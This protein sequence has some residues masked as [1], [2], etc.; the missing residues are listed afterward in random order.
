M[1]PPDFLK[2]LASLPGLDLQAFIGV[3]QEEQAPTSIR[4]NPL[5]TSAINALFEGTHAVPWSRLGHYLPDRPAFALDPLWHAGAYYVQEASSMVIEQVWHQWM[6]PNNQNLRV[7]DLCAAPGGKSTHLLSLLGEQDLLVSNEVIGS[8]ANVLLENITKWGYVNSMVTNND[9]ADFSELEGLFDMIVVDA[10]CSGSGLFR[11]DPDAAEEWSLDAVHLCQKRQQRILADVWPALKEEGI[12]IY[13]TCSYSEAEDET[14]LDWL[15]EHFGATSLPVE[16]NPAWKV[17]P[18]LSPK[19]GAHGYRF[20]QHLLEGEGFFLS[21]VRKTDA[22]GVFHSKGRQNRRQ[23]IPGHHELG[24]WI[25]D[26]Q[27][28]LFHRH[29]DTLYAMPAQVHEL[30]H[31]VND[32]LRIRK[33]GVCLGEWQRNGL[34]PDHALAMSALVNEGITQQALSLEQ[35][36]Q[37]LRKATFEWPGHEKGWQLAAYKGV[38]LGWVKHLGNRFNNYFPSAWRLRS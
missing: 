21:V 25:T 1:L 13:T 8:R 3:H 11:R 22:A 18:T 6:A 23:E 7:L 30:F 38:A 14:V 28:Y 31:Q 37:Y 24:D 12:L 19:Q 15:L 36:Q 33:A 29:E 4:I 35:A 32:Q 5:K 17:V 10:P 16:M 34:Q 20:Y 27:Q 9:P 2:S 26:P